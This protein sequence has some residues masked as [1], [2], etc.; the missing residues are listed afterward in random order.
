MTAVAGAPHIALVVEGPGD[1]QAV[2]VLLRKHQSSN[3]DYADILG[4]PVPFHGKGNAT[5]PGGIEGYVATAA[6]PGCV[7]VIV[8]LD[9][10][11]D[12]VC[13]QG[14]EL[15]ERARAEVGVPVVIAIAERDFEDWLFA[16]VETLELHNPSEFDTN[17]RGK[18]GIQRGMAPQKYVK[19]THQPRL[20]SKADLALAASRSK[21]LARLLAKFDSLR[22]LI[23]A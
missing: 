13:V 2:P 1:V 16:S 22:S 14:P 5:A 15:L 19:P 9:A 18:T 12:L 4:K 17:T 7:G 11:D 3:E 23:D 8:V 6:R 20:T 10:D 21:S